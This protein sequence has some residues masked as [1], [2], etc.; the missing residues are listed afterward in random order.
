MNSS[1]APVENASS[2]EK[3]R[4]SSAD[5]DRQGPSSSNAPVDVWEESEAWDN[6]ST[7]RTDDR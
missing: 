1:V 5:L 6:P 7:S 4:H 3:I 2:A